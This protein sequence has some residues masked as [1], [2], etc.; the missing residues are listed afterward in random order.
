MSHMVEMASKSQMFHTDDG[1]RWRKCLTPPSMLHEVCWTASFDAEPGVNKDILFSVMVIAVLLGASTS[2]IFLL[3]L[4]FVV[5][6]I[7]TVIDSTTG[8]L[9]QIYYQATSN[10]TGATCLLMFN[11]IAM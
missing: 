3:V 7:D 4:L 8:P 1:N 5:S 6:D 11:V 9:L 2:W 10:R